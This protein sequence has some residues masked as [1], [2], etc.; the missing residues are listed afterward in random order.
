MKWQSSEIA[1]YNK[2]IYWKEEKAIEFK[3]YIRTKYNRISKI[4]KCKLNGYGEHWH[5]TTKE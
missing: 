1:C 4:Y 5:L 2:K 3:E